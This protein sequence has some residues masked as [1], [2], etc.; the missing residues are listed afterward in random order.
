VCAARACA[1]HVAAAIAVAARTRA[2]RVAA[3]IAAAAG[4]RA[5]AGTVASSIK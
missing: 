5:V 4:P 2:G 3:A 1:G